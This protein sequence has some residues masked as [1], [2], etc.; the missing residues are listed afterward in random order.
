MI[1]TYQTSTAIPTPEPSSAMRV[2]FIVSY[3][4]E[5]Q[6]AWMSF[7]IL[8]VEIV[9]SHSRSALPDAT[10]VKLPANQRIFFAFSAT[11]LNMWRLV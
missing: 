10:M 5:I 8:I 7:R 9:H 1:A 4:D 11:W 2:L 6:R 3:R